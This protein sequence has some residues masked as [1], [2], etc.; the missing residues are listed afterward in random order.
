M[1]GVGVGVGNGPSEVMYKVVEQVEGI[2]V[3]GGNGR[4]WLSQKRCGMSRCEGVCFV[5]WRR[6][7][8]YRRK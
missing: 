3:R 1:V 7:N 2:W 6:K 4:L 5:K 8:Q